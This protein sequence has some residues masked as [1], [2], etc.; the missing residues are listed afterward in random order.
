MN[1][2][3]KTLHK[4]GL[5]GGSLHSW[6]TGWWRGVKLGGLCIREMGREG[7]GGVRK[8]GEAHRYTVIGRKSNKD[9][10]RGRG[11]TQARREEKERRK[12]TDAG[13]GGKIGRVKSVYSGKMDERG[14]RRA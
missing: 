10:N 3:K 12:R 2:K 13:D 1:K 9:E 14:M 8:K 7:G 5:H 11:E 6:Q 4:P